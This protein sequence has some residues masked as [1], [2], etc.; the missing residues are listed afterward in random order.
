MAHLPAGAN[1]AFPIEMQRARAARQDLPLL[2][3]G[4]DEIIHHRVGVAR[5]IAQRPTCYRTNMLLELADDA[6]V[7][8]PVS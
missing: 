8:R 1:L 2:C 6:G 3:F 5:R 7:Q 4:A